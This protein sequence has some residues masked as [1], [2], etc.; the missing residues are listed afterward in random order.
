MTDHMGE[1]IGL[2]CIHSQFLLLFLLWMGGLGAAAKNG[3]GG[4]R[5]GCDEKT[6][7]E[8]DVI[9]LFISY[10]YDWMNG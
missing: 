2:Y 5:Y 3:G 1:G 7:Q 10:R 8:V 6:T 9:V 4:W